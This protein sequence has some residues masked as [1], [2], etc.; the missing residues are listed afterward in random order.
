MVTVL[1]ETDNSCW[2]AGPGR[3]PSGESGGTISNLNTSSMTDSEQ[4]T[5]RKGEKNPVRFEEPETDVTN[6]WAARMSDG[7]PLHNGSAG[8]FCSKVK[9]QQCWSRRETKSE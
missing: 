7:V 1:R 4:S 8:Y 9:T 5:V 2:M 3:N 6:S